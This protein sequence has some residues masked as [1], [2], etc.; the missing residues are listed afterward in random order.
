MTRIS[1]VD[2]DDYYQVL[3]LPRDASNSEVTKAYRKLALQYH[4]DKQQENKSDSE[5]KF[6]QIS[7]AYETLHDPEKRT[8][9]DNFGK[10]AMQQ[11]LPKGTKNSRISA[12]EIDF[13]FGFPG[14]RLPG[15]SDKLFGGLGKELDLEQLYSAVN[16]DVCQRKRQR[17]TQPSPTSRN[18]FALPRGKMVTVHGLVEA[19]EHNGKKA[20]VLGYDAAKG[21][22][23]VKMRSDGPVICVKP[24]NLTQ[25]CGMTVQGLTAQPHLN[26]QT[27]DIMG[28]QPDS[29]NYM[30]ILR[31]SSKMIYISPRNCILDGGTCIRLRG[32]SAEEL[33]GQL[34]RVLE[35]DLDAG[36]YRVQCRDGQEIRVKYE[37]AL[38]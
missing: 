22:Y 10:H 23:D 3:G 35:A 31:K 13:L 36:R 37:N 12:E 1:N 15:C 33:N 17:K 20:Q 8:T 28:F 16:S 30:A 26:G 4:P 14:G 27:A 6:K 18:P 21:R 5:A 29:G 32:L 34:A 19:V 9:Y 25:H 2:S 11:D 24:E 7:E 38:C